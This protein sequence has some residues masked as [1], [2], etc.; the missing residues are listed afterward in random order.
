MWC[1]NEIEYILEHLQDP[2]RLM[3]GEF[4]EWLEKK[5][6]LALFEKIRNQREAFLRLQQEG[7]IDIN[8]EFRCFESKISSR[9]SL[10]RK[11]GW[12]AVAACMVLAM[13]VG[14]V[15]KNDESSPF[16]SEEVTDLTGKKCYMSGCNGM[17]PAMFDVQPVARKN[18]IHQSELPVQLCEE[19]LEYVT[20]EGEIIL[21]SFAGSGAV[22][23]AALNKKRS[24]I[25]IEILKENI[26]K[27]RTRFNS[28]LYQTVLE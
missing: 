13:V 11:G 22:G 2:E 6:H 12:V 25:L 16:L 19:I 21:D 23:V 20:Y 26:E 24:C 7:N 15:M 17:L 8:V 5:E 4:V 14:I 9:K 28:V 1:E 18:K 3:D 27:I 10:W